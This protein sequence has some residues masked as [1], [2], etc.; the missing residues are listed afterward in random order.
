[1]A[2]SGVL[3][4]V[5]FVSTNVSEE[6]IAFIISLTV[7]VLRLLV[8]ANVFPCSL[9]LVTLLVEALRSSE[10]S[11]LT[12]ATRRNIP[13]DGILYSD[14][15]GNLKSDVSIYWRH[16]KVRQDREKK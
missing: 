3:H 16:Q 10:T 11:V 4:R 2:F 7:G 1:M 5:A 8:T 6:L 15:R 9:I 12:R 14:H 13:K